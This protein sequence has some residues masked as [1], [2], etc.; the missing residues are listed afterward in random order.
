MKRLV[1]LF[2]A[3]AGALGA[4]GCAGVSSI[5]RYGADGQAEYFVDCSGRGMTSCY[6]RALRHCP[7]GYFLVKDKQVADGSKSGSFW[8]SYKAVGGA[9]NNTRT[10]WKNQVVVRCK[11]PGAEAPQ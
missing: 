1:L 2:A 4:A 3:G 8:G 10:N 5:L 7:Q 9:A 6:A 11:A